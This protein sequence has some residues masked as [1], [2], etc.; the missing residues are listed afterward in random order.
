VGKGLEAAWPIF[1]AIGA[2]VL[3]VG[4]LGA[5][6]TVRHSTRLA[7]SGIAEIDRMDGRTFEERLAVLFRQLGYKVDLV[8]R[9]G[10][11]GADLCLVRRRRLCQR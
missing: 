1:A 9:T 10:D 2:F 4:L 6:M 5:I 11:F 7:R 3:I 8:G